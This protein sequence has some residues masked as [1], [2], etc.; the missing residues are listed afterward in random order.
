MEKTII[1]IEGMSCASCARGLEGALKET[2]GV[3]EA[4]VNFAAGKAYLTYDPEQ[5]SIE[6]ILQ[7]I[8]EA[9]YEGKAEK[10]EDITDVVLKIGGMSCASC[11]LTLESSLKKEPGVLE[12]SVNFAAEKA[13]VK[14]D[15][16]KVSR[17]GLDELVLFA[18]YE[19]FPTHLL[20]AF[21]K[22]ARCQRQG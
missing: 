9:G 20:K 16:S 4:S 11:A 5:L 2:E 21:R 6:E 22:Q 1:A 3:K 17:A 10:D 13:I 18:G 12:A 15:R 7:R 14:Y 8:S 19:V